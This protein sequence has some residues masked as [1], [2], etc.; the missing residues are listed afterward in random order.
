MGVWVGGH[1][2]T[3]FQYGFTRANDEKITMIISKFRYLGWL[4]SGKF[5]VIFVRK[6][7][8]EQ[9]DGGDFLM[10]PVS[11]YW[12]QNH[13]D[14][15]CEWFNKCTESV[16]NIPNWSPDRI[17]SKD[18]FGSLR[19]SFRSLD[20][21]S[22]DVTNTNDHQFSSPTAMYPFLTQHQRMHWSSIH[23]LIYLKCII[24]HFK[25][26]IKLNAILQNT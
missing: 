15:L 4:S 23:E 17:F 5:P 14:L 21:W 7:Q 1:L 3:N 8:C 10:M 26:F 18:S 25:K 11:R 20:P 24:L 9:S 22:Q 13:Y 6:R 16:N 12:W 2:P 19:P